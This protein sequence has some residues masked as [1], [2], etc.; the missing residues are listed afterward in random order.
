MTKAQKRLRELRERQSKERQKMAELSLVETLTDEQRSELDGIEA[1]T[2]DLERQ[3]RAAQTALETEEREA[4]DKGADAA[5]M[6]RTP[7]CGSASSFAASANV[8]RVSSR[9]RCEG[10]AAGPARKPNYRQAAGVDGIPV[11]AVGHAERTAAGPRTAP[12]RRS[13]G[14]RGPESRHAAAGFVF[15]P[16]HRVKA[17]GHRHARCVESGTYASAT[18]NASRDRRRRCPRSGPARACH[19]PRDWTPRSKLRPRPRTA[20]GAKLDLTVIGRHR[21]PSAQANFESPLAASIFPSCWPPK[22]TTKLTQRR[23]AAA[24]T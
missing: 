12:S 9:Q 3:L 6:R 11:G 13:A 17:H 1:G 19:V 2:P 24:T 22:S 5:A 8:G 15:A 4:K 20:I 23:W 16:S 21:H 10:R 14:H 18:I 7:K